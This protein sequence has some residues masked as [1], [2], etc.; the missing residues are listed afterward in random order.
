MFLPAGLYSAL[1]IRVITSFHNFTFNPRKR[2]ETSFFHL[3]GL[4]QN[5]NRPH[6]RKTSNDQDNLVPVSGFC[7]LYTLN[8][9]PRGSKKQIIEA[10]LGLLIVVT[11]IASF[12][13]IGWRW[14]LVALISPFVLISLFR[15]LAQSVA[16]RVL[17][18]RTGFDD[19]PESINGLIEHMASG[20]EGFKRAFE[21]IGREAEKRGQRL[22]TLAGKSSISSVLQ[23]HKVSFD[24]YEKLFDSLWSS[25]LHDLAWEIVSTPNDLDSLIQMKRQGKSD[26]EIWS[27]FRDFK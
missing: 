15:P 13:V 11:V 9:F 5:M 25:A 17:G 12:F 21:K 27:H 23:R 4:S 3:Y 8:L 10:V 1:F 24:E 18:Y 19:Q 2:L 7:F 26:V 22:S 6:R 14:G 16:Y 20:E